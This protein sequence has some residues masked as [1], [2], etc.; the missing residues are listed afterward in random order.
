MV[1]KD[2]G[3]HAGVAVVSQGF[4]A[5]G[6]YAAV[7]FLATCAALPAHLVLWLGAL[8]LLQQGVSHMVALD[9]LIFY[10]F[11]LRHKFVVDVNHQ[12]GQTLNLH[13]VL[14]LEVLDR[15]VKF[16]PLVFQVQHI[17]LF[18]ADLGGQFSLQVVIPWLVEFKQ[19]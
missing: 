5:V 18:H 16:C 17:D 19:S 11:V 3:L 9:A 8:E 13:I 10:F 7:H 15:G 14:L 6:W 1:E 4:D 2:K 12:V